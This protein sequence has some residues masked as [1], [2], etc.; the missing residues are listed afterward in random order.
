MF[1]SG[2]GASVFG[3]SDGGGE[4]GGPVCLE[5]VMVEGRGEGQCGWRW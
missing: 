4:G 1:G 5:V 3:G 2:G